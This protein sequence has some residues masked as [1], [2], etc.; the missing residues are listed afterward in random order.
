MGKEIDKRKA[1]INSLAKQGIT[2]T[3]YHAIIHPSQPNYLAS[4]GGR[5]H[6]LLLDTFLRLGKSEKTIVDLLEKKGVS[7]GEYQEGLPYSGFQG[8]YKNQENGK[9]NYVR[10]HN[11]LMTYDS[12]TSDVDRLAKIKNFTMFD[13]DLKNNQL[14][15]WM[16]I[17]PN[18]STSFFLYFLSRFANQHL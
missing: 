12:V 7:W 16:F 2:L 15:Q 13:T 1:S 9:N 4:A 6:G 3:D 5:T 17:T 14:P 10:K 18:M 8:D 11:P